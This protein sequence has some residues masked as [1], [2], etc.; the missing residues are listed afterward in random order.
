MSEFFLGW[1]YS[2]I[3]WAVGLVLFYP[4]PNSDPSL[5]PNLNPNANPNP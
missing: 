1:G 5:N 2:R 3:S 4:N